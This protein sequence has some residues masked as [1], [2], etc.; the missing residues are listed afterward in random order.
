MPHTDKIFEK[1][2]LFST[3]LGK[4]MK[5]ARNVSTATSFQKPPSGNAGCLTGLKS[6][7]PKMAIKIS[8]DRQP[9][10]VESK[11][12]CIMLAGIFS[13]RKMLNFIF[14]S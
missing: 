7:H 14:P 1:P 5:T 11:T 8:P 2:P 4:F 3:F 9:S 12:L 6:E 13:L 10:R